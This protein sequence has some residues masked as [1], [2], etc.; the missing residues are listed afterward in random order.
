MTCSLCGTRTAQPPHG[1]CVMC[2]A[3]T[4]DQESP[5]ALDPTGWVKGR[6]G[7]WRHVQAREVR[8]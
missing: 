8:T 4:A 7:I 3:I 1:M 5:R 2:R 6:R